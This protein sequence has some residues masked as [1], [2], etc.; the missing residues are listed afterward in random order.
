MA[1]KIANER[2]ISPPANVLGAAGLPCFH[3]PMAAAKPTRQ[4]STAK[5]EMAAL[6][7][8]PML[9]IREVDSEVIV[10]LAI[11][12]LPSHL[13]LPSDDTADCH[14]APSQK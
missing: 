6:I 10:L 4:T 7:Q 11:H 12:S 13:H 5:A 2:K 9:R 8:L 14:W 3:S 1:N